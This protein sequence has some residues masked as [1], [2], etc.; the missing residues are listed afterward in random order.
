MDIIGGLPVE[1]LAFR[2]NAG[3]QPAE[4]ERDVD[5]RRDAVLDAVAD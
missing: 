1:I 2:K 3:H 4:G 5:S